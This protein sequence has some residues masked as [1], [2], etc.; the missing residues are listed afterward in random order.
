MAKAGLI[1]RTLTGR[2]PRYQYKTD[3]ICSYNTRKS[4]LVVRDG[5][6]SI[7]TDKVGSECIDGHV[8]A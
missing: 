6:T 1:N 3:A 4:L 2:I 7:K 8:L 5:E